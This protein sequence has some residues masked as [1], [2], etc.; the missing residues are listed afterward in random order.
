MTRIARTA[1]CLL[2]TLTV[3]LACATKVQ[4]PPRVL[5]SELGTIGVVDFAGG[6]DAALAS[7]A[8]REFVQMLHAAQPGSR[9][10]ELGSESR[11]LAEVGHRELDFEAARAIGERFR[12]DAV[13]IGELSLSQAKPN[14]RFGQSFTS[15]RAS[16]DISGRL[17]TRLMEADAGAT[18][19]SRN[20]TATASVARVGLPE[21]GTPSFGVQDPEDTQ[22]GLVRQLVANLRSDFYPTWRKQ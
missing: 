9:V 17:A 11:V 6:D 12:V 16:A 10:L 5:L 3:S 20:A 18:I 8:T 21:G 14:I 2:G 13:L 4:V 19:W 1:L 7:L 15:V 22:A